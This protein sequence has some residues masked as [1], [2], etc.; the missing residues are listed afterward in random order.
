MVRQILAK[1]DSPTPYPTAG[2][3]VTMTAEDITNHSRF[4]LTG[5]EV[6]II[7]NSGAS[8][9]TYTIASAVDAQGRTKDITTQA[10]VAGAIHTVGP[11]TQQPGW[12]QTDGYVYVDASNAA[13]KFGVIQ[14]G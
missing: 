5:R 6:L 10:I 12:A 4:L 3:A 1:T 2:V 13:V 11:F 9:Y 8:G 7:W 14:L